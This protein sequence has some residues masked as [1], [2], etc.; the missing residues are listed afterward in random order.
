MI[1][2]AS[3][4]QCN[5]IHICYIRYFILHIR[6]QNRY[7]KLNSIYILLKRIRFLVK[8]MI[9]YLTIICVP[10]YS[11]H[12]L[13]SLFVSF[14]PISY[15][16]QYIFTVRFRNWLYLKAK[17]TFLK[18]LLEEVFFLEYIFIV[19]FEVIKSFG[20]SIIE[21]EKQNWSW[22]SN[23]LA[24]I[25]NMKFLLTAYFSFIRKYKIHFLNNGLCFINQYFH[26]M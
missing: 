18:N 13:T 12:L 22:K 26:W 16:F 1:A 10:Q 6:I 14:F 8:W 5:L 20:L 17:K 4:P 3:S 9:R 19:E 11:L 15:N 21:M 2:C 25:R 7:L 23:A 24:E